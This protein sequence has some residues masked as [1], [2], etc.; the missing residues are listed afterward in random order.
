MA[1]DE[2]AGREVADD[3]RPTGADA[4]H[5]EEQSVGGDSTTGWEEA[6]RMELNPDAF[7]EAEDGYAIECPE[8]GSQTP[9]MRIAETGRCDG[10][11]GDTVQCS[12]LLRVELAW[13]S[14]GEPE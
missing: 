10:Y 4:T 12:A 11:R 14:E 2:D 5:D 6:G 13:K 8:C 7:L 1:N 3:D 9:F